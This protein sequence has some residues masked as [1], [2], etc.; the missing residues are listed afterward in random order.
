MGFLMFAGLVGT[1]GYMAH[2]AKK[3]TNA[4]IGDSVLQPTHNEV[5]DK[6]IIENNFELICKRCDIKLNSDNKPLY[7]KQY[8]PC[9]A[10]LQYQGFS[11]SVAN[12]FQQIY[13]ARYE[14]KHQVKNN[15]IKNKHDRIFETYYNTF[16]QKVTQVVRYWHYGDTEIKCKKMMKNLLWSTLVDDYNIVKDGSQNVEVW[17]ISASPVILEQI[18]DI[19]KEVCHLEGIIKDER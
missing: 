17:I 4:I 3:E 8:R 6:Q 2:C 9:V 14:N 1:L 18:D 19:Y 7:E 12:H 11:T 13:L 5:K 10:Y 15:D 16:D